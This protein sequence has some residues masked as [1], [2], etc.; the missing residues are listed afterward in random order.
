MGE[1]PAIG[2][3][4]L[5]SRTEEIDLDSGDVREEPTPPFLKDCNRLGVGLRGLQPVLLIKFRGM[6]TRTPRFVAADYLDGG[7]WCSSS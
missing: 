4:C 2:G 3:M 1:Y 6:L 7:Q 5:R